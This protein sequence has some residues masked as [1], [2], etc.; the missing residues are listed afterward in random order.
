VWLLLGPENVLKQIPFWLAVAFASIVWASIVFLVFL[1]LAPYRLYSEI[2]TRVGKSQ[3]E[4]GELQDAQI[5]RL[6]ISFESRDSYVQVSPQSL[7]YRISVR[8]L[9]TTTSIESV[10]VELT[11]IKP[12]RPSH[13]PIRLH[14]MNDNPHMGANYQQSFEL[15]PDEVKYFDLIELCEHP[16]GLKFLIKHIA[17]NVDPQLTEPVEALTV[18]ARGKH[19]PSVTA[20]FVLVKQNNTYRLSTVQ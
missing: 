18:V 5:P 16:A 15:A 9:S 3:L 2:V 12:Y 13:L 1:V 6:A 4:I 17:R 14:L 19:C 11:N 10:F 7:L 8:N 20:E